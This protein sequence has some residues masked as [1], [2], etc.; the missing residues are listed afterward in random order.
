MIADKAATR[1][2]TRPS[3]LLAIAS[4]AIHLLVN[5]GY[6]F[7]RDELYF[8]VCGMHPAWGYVDQPPL[9]PLIA[10]TS[11]AA[12]GDW[13]L[14]FRIVPALAMTAMVALTAEFARLVGG[15]RFAQWLAGFCALGAAIFLAHGLLLSTDMFQALTWLGS[16]WCIVRI[17]QT[18]DQRWWIAFGLIIGFSLLTKYLIAF[19]LAALVP[20][21][22]MSP[23]RRSLA[24]PWIY[25]G[26]GLALAMV[27]PNILWQQ[28]QGWP[29]LELGA[30]GA[31]HKNLALSPLGFFSQQLLLIGPLTAAVWLTGLWATAVRP[32]H[33]AYRAFPIAYGLLFAFFVISHGKA[34]YLAPIY[35][36]LLG[37]GAVAIE[38]WLTAAWTRGTALAAIAISSALVAPMAVPVLPVQTYIAYANAMGMSPSA[39]AGEH[40]RLSGLPQHF[41]D[42][43]GW[44]EMAAD[45]E[46]VWRTL[47]PADQ[48]RAVV[49]GQNYGEAAAIDVFGH[50][51]PPAISGHNN[52]YV[53]GPRGHDGNVMVVIGGD[54][55]E[56]EGLFRSVTLAGRIASP[57]AMP[58]ETN[59]PIYILRGARTPLPALWP[60]LKHFE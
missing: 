8:I 35:P 31:S 2:W 48:A 28:H 6:G 27:L 24:R 47:S 58:Y 42:M 33:A 44:R 16:S 34:Y 9:V 26:V 59:L 21:L 23:L 1:D 3:L 40:Q 14:G 57:H 25:A 20:G 50:G 22:L 17:A 30:A 29:F 46:A 7:F 39:L 32:A 4:L 43:F 11:R 54:A 37:F 38:R 36:V 19:F 12:F 45:V 5:G 56:M 60:S 15:G 51:L 18:D 52:Y 10:A 13:L 49:F 41:A 55:K 53:W